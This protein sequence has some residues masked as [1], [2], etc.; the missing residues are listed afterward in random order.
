M[1]SQNSLKK[2]KKK[3]IEGLKIE[4]F[5]KNKKVERAMLS[6]P[7]EEFVLERERP[8]AYADTPQG[9][10]FGQTISAPH[11]V[12]IMTELLDLKPKDKVLEVGGGSGY[13]AAVLAKLAKKVYSIELEQ[14]LVDFAAANLKK[15]RIK[16]VEVRQGDGSAGWK[17]HAP[18]DKIVVTC[19]C[20]QV[21]KA[22]FGQLKSSGVLVAP[23]GG[24]WQQDLMLYRK[25][26]GKKGKTGLEEK[27]YG[28]CVFVPLRH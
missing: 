20:S 12:A 13:Q 7:R 18:Y 9:I 26:V 14:G 24:S 1:V 15:A 8:Y 23:V 3:L 4:G 27:G 17:E 21:P 22:L 5:L 11:M 6:V 19:A 2:E 16:N 25:L 28:G 10:G